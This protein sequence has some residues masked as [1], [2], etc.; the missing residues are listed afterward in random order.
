MYHL[1]FICGVR[2][3]QFSLK[4][5]Q[6]RSKFILGLDLRSIYTS[7]QKPWLARIFT[8]RACLFL[9]A[10]NQTYCTD[11]C[12]FTWQ[13]SEHH[14]VFCSLPSFPV[15]WGKKSGKKKKKIE[16]VGLWVEIKLFTK[17]EKRIIVMTVCICVNVNNRGCTSTCSPPLDQ[18]SASPPS[19]VRE[20]DECPLPSKFLL[21]GIV[22][23][24]PWVSLCQLS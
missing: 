14:A 9:W 7:L 8:I 13:V 18:C 10:F 6:D 11:C 4:Y 17:I 19:S 23:N 22:W 21:L 16:F 24:I 12:G 20:R 3:N 5:I 1:F 2:L 15:W